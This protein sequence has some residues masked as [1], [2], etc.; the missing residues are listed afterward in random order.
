[1]KRAGPA[2]DNYEF[3]ANYAA[4]HLPPGA[5]VLDYGCGG[6]RIVTL[7]R[8]RG[9]EAVGCDVFFEGGDAS[10]EIAPGEVGKSI[11]RMEGDEIPFRDSYFDF[12]INNQVLEHVADLDAVVS[13]IARVLKPGGTVLSLFPDKGVWWEG[14]SHVP[15][16]HWFPKGSRFRVNYAQLVRI[17]G[18]GSF[19]KNKSRRQWAKDFCVWLDRWTYYRS[20][21]EIK[22]AFSRHLSRPLHLESEWMEARLGSR[23]RPVPPV[24]RSLITRKLGGLI[25][26]A[27][28][29]GEGIA[30][31]P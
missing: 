12:V 5:R 13:E 21:A 27:S 28:K 23:V 31:S 10:A 4:S 30:V 24:I 9:F 14:H 3:C 11:F 19:K 7:L 26:V 17:C 18:G 20:R 29:P 8:A 22:A 16:L 25:F 1:M 6:G 15:F 2:M